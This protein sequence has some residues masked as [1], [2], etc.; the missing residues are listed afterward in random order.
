MK[1]KKNT[2]EHKGKAE[3]IATVTTVETKRLNANLPSDLYKKLK[4]KATN[5]D[6]TIND[7][8]NEWAIEYVSE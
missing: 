6:K 8:V 5:E 2:R 4:L 3:A 7:L 1:L